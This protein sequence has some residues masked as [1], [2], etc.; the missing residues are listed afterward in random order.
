M[1][2]LEE[3]VS[4]TITRL[5]ATKPGNWRDILVEFA[6]NAAEASEAEKKDKGQKCA[7]CG[8]LVVPR[9]ISCAAKKATKD[10]AKGKAREYGPML[11]MKA[12]EGLSKLFEDE[13]PAQEP[14]DKPEEPAP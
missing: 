1:A 9:C 2:T 12:M 7:G 13:D 8:K 3:E 4:A 10:F 11:A 5:A 14:D 6:K